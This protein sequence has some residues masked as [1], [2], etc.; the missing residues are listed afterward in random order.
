MQLSKVLFILKVVKFDTK[1]YLNFS[2]FWGLTSAG[3]GTSLGSKTG[4]SVRW[5]GLATFLP[6]GGPPSPP[7]EKTCIYSSLSVQGDAS[8]ELETKEKK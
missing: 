7:R 8:S 6:D 2:N 3:G 4:T 1:M 5:G